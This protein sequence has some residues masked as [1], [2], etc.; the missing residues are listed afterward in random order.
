VQ[1][2]DEQLRSFI[3]SVINEINSLPGDN[4]QGY[5]KKNT[6]GQF[7]DVEDAINAAEKAQK[8]L[9]AMT[10]EKR[11]E[12]I[13]SIRKN[14]EANV[15]LLSKMAFEETGMGRIEDKIKK[16]RLAVRKTPGIEDIKSEVFTGDYGLTLVE[17]APFGVIGSIV[18]STNPTATIINNS[19][20]MISGGNSVVFNP[21]PSAKKCSCKTVE[22]INMASVEVGGPDNLVNSVTEPTMASSK[23]IMQHPKIRLLSVTGGPGIVKIS[24][25]SG[26]K[27][28]VA[29][30]GNPPV[31]VDSTADIDN[32]A[33]SIL[34]GASFD[35]NILCIAE[36]EVFAESKILDTLMDK[37]EALGAYRLSLS[38]LDELMNYIVIKPAQDGAEPVIN[39]KLVGKNP[40]EILKHIHI[41]VP[42][43]V[44]LVI[45]EVPREHP[46]VMIEQLMPVLPFVRVDNVDEG[47]QLAYKAESGCHHTAMMFSKNVTDLTKMAKLLDT[48]IFVKNAPSYS[49]LGFNGEGFSSLTIATPT[50]EGLTSARTFTRLRRCVLKDDLRIV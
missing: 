43:S 41:D 38:Q 18:P 10:L 44:R 27:A 45:C 11:A 14:V 33:K 23:M 3:Y 48:T 31:V 47:I 6:F 9:V 24:L 1:V 15:E 36:K 19:I 4:E 5:D 29:G 2:T 21:H 7:T 17:R 49:G 40:R 13:A 8:K 25:Q 30:P 50:G 22:I 39:R 37:I 32:A 20:S 46:L 35:N 12:I 42:D 28:I 16:N 34:E 26:K